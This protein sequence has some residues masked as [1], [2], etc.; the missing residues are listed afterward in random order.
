VAQPDRLIVVAGEALVDRFVGPEGI[1]GETLGGGPFNIAR[2]IARLGGRVAF[3]G[4]LSSDHAGQRLRD[5][6]AADGVDLSLIQATDARTTS[7][8]VEL[9][10]AGRASY[11]FDLD[12][13]AAA[14]LTPP[15]GGLPPGT[16]ALEV[17]S[18]GIVAAP[19]A[20]TLEALVASADPDALVLV[21]PNCRP[22]ATHDPAELRARFERLAARADVVRASRDDLAYLLP[23]SAPGSAESGLQRLGP[24]LVIV[25]DGDGPVVVRG[26]SFGF[27]LAVEPVEVVDTVGTGDA[28][29]GAFL[30]DWIGGGRSRAELA[31]AGAVRSSVAFAIDVAR[32]TARRIGADPPRLAELD[33]LR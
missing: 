30:A 22:S 11:R 24:R 16:A 29:A 32:A 12:G 1:R 10:A 8:E 4:A 5:A 15:D 20:T 17:G 23:G 21:D 9:D 6:L 14:G 7:A 2:T 19:I 33:R 31:D 26:P 13:T 18:L 28:F 25:T 27:E 3:L